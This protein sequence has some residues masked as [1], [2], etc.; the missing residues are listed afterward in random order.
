MMVATFF[1]A[2]TMVA[3]AT[4]ACVHVDVLHLATASECLLSRGGRAVTLLWQ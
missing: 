3:I 2:T 1:L 4:T